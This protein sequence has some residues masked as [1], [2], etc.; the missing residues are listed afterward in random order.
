MTFHFG[1]WTSDGEAALACTFHLAV[2]P[3]ALPS[4]GLYSAL[5]KGCVVDKPFNSLSVQIGSV[6]GIDDPANPTSMRLYGAV[7]PDPDDPSLVHVWGILWQ[8]TVMTPVLYGSGG[9][10]NYTQLVTPNRKQVVLGTSQSMDYNGLNCLD[11]SFGYAPT[12]PSLYPDD[13]S[14]HIEGDAPEQPFPPG[15]SSVSVLDSFVTYTL[16]QPPGN[17]SCLVPLKNLNWYWQGSAANNAS[18]SNIWQISNTNAQ[19][20][21]LQDFPVH[22]VWQYNVANGKTFSPPLPF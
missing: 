13:G 1:K 18:T 7:M 6:Q 3:G 21:F 17:G 4:S 8:G 10:W 19:W 22:P 14:S 5:T 12:Y 20:S 16:Y 15:G 11:T 9:G 2:P